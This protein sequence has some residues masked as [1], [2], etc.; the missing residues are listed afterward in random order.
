MSHRIIIIKDRIQPK[1]TLVNNILEDLISNGYVSKNLIMPP[2]TPPSMQAQ[3][4]QSLP[5]MPPVYYDKLQIKNIYNF[6]LK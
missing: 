2:M 4:M 3:S 6:Q 1:T 5:P